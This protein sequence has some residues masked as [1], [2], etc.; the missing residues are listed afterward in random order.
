MEG[1]MR[2]RGALHLPHQLWG[3]AWGLERWGGPTLPFSLQ[4]PETL[5]QVAQLAFLWAKG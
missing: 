3:A 5:P 1:G 4:L 2:H